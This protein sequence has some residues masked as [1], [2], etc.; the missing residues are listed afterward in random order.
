MSDDEPKILPPWR[1]FRARY[2]DEQPQEYLNAKFEDAI[3]QARDRDHWL[4][5][6]FNAVLGNVELLRNDLIG[7]GTVLRRGILTVILEKQEQFPQ[8]VRNELRDAR[9]ERRSRE[10]TAARKWALGMSSAAAAAI[11]A[12]LVMLWVVH[13]P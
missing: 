11:V 1:E 13:H 10:W 6:Q 12:A 9:I 7:D 3:R 4:T 8:L 5:S 2:R